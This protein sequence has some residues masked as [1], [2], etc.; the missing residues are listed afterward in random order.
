MGAD[1]PLLE[2]KG[3]YAGIEGNEI[4]KGIDLEINPEKF[5]DHSLESLRE[6]LA[7]IENNI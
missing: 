5:N 1:N 4:L 3:L 7:E 2:I 6:V